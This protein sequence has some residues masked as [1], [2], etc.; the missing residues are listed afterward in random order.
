MELDI[1]WL[2]LFLG[3]SGVAGAI[4]LLRQYR[5]SHPSAPPTVREYKNEESVTAAVQYL[6]KAVLEI[7]NAVNSLLGI[8][9]T[10]TEHGVKI[11]GLHRTT[12]RQGEDIMDM[13]REVA[14]LEDRV[15]SL[16]RRR[17]SQP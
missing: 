15:Q 8:S 17:H 16:E 14:G 3:S 12:L 7:T 11:D 5:R 6:K 1:A 2:K 4:A 9:G 10:V 13:R